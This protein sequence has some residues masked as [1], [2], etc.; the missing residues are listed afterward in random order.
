MSWQGKTSDKVVCTAINFSKNII[1]FFL[2]RSDVH[3]VCQIHYL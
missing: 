1:P 2:L 3:F